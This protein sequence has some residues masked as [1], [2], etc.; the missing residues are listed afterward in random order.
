VLFLNGD[1]QGL[2]LVEIAVSQ[3]RSSRSRPRSRRRASSITSLSR[4][5]LRAALT[6][7]ARRTLSSRV[8][9]ALA[10]LNDELERDHALRIETRTGVGNLV[11]AE[12]ARPLAA[13]SGSKLGGDSGAAQG[14]EQ[15]LLLE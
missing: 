3:T 7:T 2:F 4:R 8:I 14:E 9:A 11:M 1:P 12:R 5:P 10:E 6:R 13:E 15:R